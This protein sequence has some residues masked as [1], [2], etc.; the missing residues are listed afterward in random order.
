[1]TDASTASASTP[2]IVPGRLRNFVEM[3]IQTRQAQRLVQGRRAADGKPP[4]IGLYRYG[5]MVRTIWAGAARDDP[6]ADWYLLKV[7]QAL[8]ESKDEIATL[9]QTIEANMARGP[10][11]KVGLAHS[12]EPA[13]IELTFS[14]PYG[15]MGAWL[16][17]AMDELV[18][19]ALT[20]R[21]VG[22]INRDAS[23]RMLGEGG[24]AVR[25]AYATAQGYRAT[26]VKREDLRQGTRRAERAKQAMGELP[27]AVLDGELRPEHAPAIERVQPSHNTAGH[28]VASYDDATTDEVTDTDATTDEHGDDDE[29]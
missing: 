14:N 22:L 20:A 21:H 12:L 7:E 26:A 3:T 17:S 9:K 1:M 13:K 6:Y 15:Y 5:A 27:Q 19:A 11:M 10:A 28:S 2:A 23:E 4:I 25:R 24:R 16:L 8:T 18:L 29:S